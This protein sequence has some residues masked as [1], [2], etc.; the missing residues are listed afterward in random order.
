MRIRGSLKA[1]LALVLVLVVSAAVLVQLEGSNLTLRPGEATVVRSSFAF[2]PQG[3]RSF[4]QSLIT[5]SGLLQVYPNSGAIYLSDDQQLDYYALVELGDFYTAGKIN[6]TMYAVLG[7]LYGN[8]S[9]AACS[10]GNWNGV[11]VVLGVYMP[12]PC[13]GSEWNMYSGRDSAIGTSDGFTVQETTWSGPMGSGYS[14]YADLDL[15]YSINQLHYGDY[16]EAVNAFERANSMWDGQGFAD[17]AFQARYGYS[18]YKLALDLIAFKELMNNSYTEGSVVSYSSVIS[19]VQDV[20]SKL[21]GSDG[22]VVTNYMF[23]NGELK[24]LSNTYENGET[25]SLLVLAE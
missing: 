23:V 20:M 17:Q 19:Q 18:S 12:I 22:G 7:G 1:F 24:S 2:D 3:A 5:P 6:S 16:T 13:Q 14:Q 21:Q 10:Y 25:T 8:F 11:D 9:S 15:Y 4:L